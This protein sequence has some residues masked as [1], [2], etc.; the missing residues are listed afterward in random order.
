M[1]SHHSHNLQA[2]TE[3]DDEFAVDSELSFL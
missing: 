1:H 3:R 2:A